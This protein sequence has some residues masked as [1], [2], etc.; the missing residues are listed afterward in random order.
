MPQQKKSFLERRVFISMV[1][2]GLSL[3]GYISYKQ[4][5]LE[6]LPF[7]E[8]PYLVVQISA[9]REMDP[10]YLEREALIPLESSV[11]LL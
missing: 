4:L 7:A 1:F 8:P 5:A 6:L 10:Q 9:G 11:G 2:L 3:L